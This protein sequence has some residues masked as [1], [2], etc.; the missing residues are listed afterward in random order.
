MPFAI[1]EQSFG[2]P[3]PHRYSREDRCGFT[4]PSPSGRLRSS[5]RRSRSTTS[6]S[7]LSLPSHGRSSTRSESRWRSR[8]STP[9]SGSERPRT[10]L[11]RYVAGDGRTPER[12]A[13][14][15]V[16]S[17]ADRA[18]ASGRDLAA[19]YDAGFETACALAESI[20]PGHCEAG[21]HATATFGTFGATGAAA[22]LSGG[23]AETTARARRSETPRR[24]PSGLIRWW[25]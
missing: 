14:P 11:R 15:R 25:I 24:H 2:S 6:P 1:A 17:L 23:D 7:P 18:D 5:Y 4:R 10:G 13:L 16:L 20:P 19:A 21:W 9:R 12:G 8:P 22:N 3:G